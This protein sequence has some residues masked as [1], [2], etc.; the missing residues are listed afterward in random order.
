[1]SSFEGPILK[2]MNP[3]SN[4]KPRLTAS[5][6]IRNKRDATIYQAEKEQFQNKKTCGNKNVK[7]YDNGTIRSMK[8]YKLQKSLARG[9]I[10]CEDCDDKGLLCKAPVDK[11]DLASIQMGNNLVSEFWGGGRIASVSLGSI[12]AG[13][14]PG[15]PVIQLDVSGVWGPASPPEVSKSDLS[16]AIL[17]NSDPSLNMPFGYINNLIDIPRN[18]D[19]SG[20]VVD[21]SNELFPDE[22]CD[23]FR[24]LQHSQLKTYVTV[25]AIVPI[26]GAFGNPFYYFTPGP[27][28]DLSYNWLVGKVVSMRSISLAGSLIGWLSGTISSVCCK[29]NIDMYIFNFFNNP[30]GEFGLFAMNIEVFY[31]DYMK[32]NNLLNKNPPFLRGGFDGG[33]GWDWGSDNDFSFWI[34]AQSWKIRLYSQHIESIKMTQGTIPPLLNQTKYNATRQSYMSCLE[35]GTRKINF[36]K[37]TKKKDNVI[38]AY[39]KPLPPSPPPPPPITDSNFLDVVDGWLNTGASVY[40][41]I[42]Y[43]DVTLVTDM[44]DAFSSDRNPNAATFNDDIIGWNTE[45]VTN[46][47]SMFKGAAAFD[48]DLGWAW[49]TSSVTDMSSMFEGAIL[50]DQNLTSW[51]TTNV[52]T[53]SSMFEGASSFDNNSSIFRWDTDALTDMSSMF[54]NAT[55][56]NK[57]IDNVYDGTKWQQPNLTNISSIFEGATAF[58]NGYLGSPDEGSHTFIWYTEYVTNMSSAFKG[59]TDF[60]NGDIPGGGIG[61]WQTQNV[62]DMSSIFESATSFNVELLGWNVNSVTNMHSMFKNTTSFNK[63]LP[64]NGNLWDTSNVTTMENMFEGASTFNQDLS[65]WFL[66]S[67]TNMTNIFNGSNVNTQNWSALANWRTQ[68]DT[69]QPITGFYTNG[70]IYTTGS[71]PPI[72]EGPEINI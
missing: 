13:Q 21:P 29:G 23:P 70:A 10:L 45:N 8:S 36:T 62:T 64:R 33:D 24:Y 69:I 68:A 54:K 47:S 72:F 19:G 26:H 27:C 67:T 53:M 14:T 50:F 18:L 65:S 28:N 20:V 11:D 56:F 58:N 60:N 39:C 17:P 55:S 43:W 16:N 49:V 42:A 1:M 59:A 71:H 6:R 30:S 3:F 34:G 61:F 37:N 25:S 41:N 2:G 46:M 52:T 66:T 22:L 44:S 32:L 4:N 7:Y 63:Q 12:G 15:F 9:N 35:N 5:E 48:Q 38:S 31:L 40:G 57:R 51:N